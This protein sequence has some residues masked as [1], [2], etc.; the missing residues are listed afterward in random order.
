V[1]DVMER[2]LHSKFKLRLKIVEFR[3][4][5]RLLVTLNSVP[6]AMSESPSYRLRCLIEGESVVFTVP[7]AGSAEVGELKE[8]IRRRREKDTLKD[9][10]SDILELWKVSA[11]DESR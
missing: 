1:P 9:V 5:T 11:I 10:G 2:S 8:L 3:S 7:V 6:I 4:G